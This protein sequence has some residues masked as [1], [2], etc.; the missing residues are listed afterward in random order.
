MTSPPRSSATTRRRTSSLIEKAYVYSA[1][2]H[3][4]QVRLSGEPYLSHPL[5]VAYILA[6]MKLDVVQRGQPVFST[7]RS[8][9]PTP[10]HERNRAALRPGSGQDRGRRHQDQQDRRSAASEEQ[11]AEN[12]R[13]MI[14][15]MA[16]DIRVILVK[17]ADRLHNMRTLG[18]QP[19]KKQE[20]IAQET[21]DIYAPLAGR[22]GIYWLK[23]E[24]E[25]LC[26]YYLEPE[27][28]EK[29]KSELAEQHGTR[30]KNSSAR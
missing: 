21:L 9:T 28:Y 5:E 13:K 25:D 23:S 7:T 1:K 26:L 20:E 29:I 4:G 22:M 19:P 2:V 27:I 16:K 10:T 30:G 8:R 11:Q 12:M 6:Q 14:L 3:Q 24:L 18:F 15:A 17:L